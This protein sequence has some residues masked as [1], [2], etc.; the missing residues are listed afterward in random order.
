MHKK[1]KACISRYGNLLATAPLFQEKELW[2]PF[3]AGINFDKRPSE[4]VTFLSAHQD[5]GKKGNMTNSKGQMRAFLFDA[6]RTPFL[7]E[8]FSPKGSEEP[9]VYSQTCNSIHEAFV[10]GT[11][12]AT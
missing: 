2:K 8:N 1:T 3:E 7:L 11:V 9:G 10:C 4:L 12:C 5:L 6:A